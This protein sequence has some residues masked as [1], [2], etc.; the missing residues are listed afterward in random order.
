MVLAFILFELFFAVID[1]FKMFQ[2]ILKSADRC[3]IRFV[4][5]IIWLPFGIF[6]LIYYTCKDTVHLVKLLCKMSE[7]EEEKQE[8]KQDED[9]RQDTIVISNELILAM[10]KIFLHLKEAYQMK[11]D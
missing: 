1:Y 2:N 11:E 6:I 5:F 7:A 8:K 4:S 3:S 9:K 10:R